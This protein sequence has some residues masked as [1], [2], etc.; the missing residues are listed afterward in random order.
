MQIFAYW[1]VPPFRTTTLD[2]EANESIDTIKKMLHD[3]FESK[4]G[5]QVAPGHL[6]LFL[7]GW[8]MEDERTLLDYGIKENWT[9]GVLVV[10]KMHVQLLSGK[11]F[12]VNHL[13]NDTIEE[14]KQNIYDDENILP[15]QQHLIFAGE[16]LDNSRT[17][18]GY[19]IPNEST[20][21]LIVSANVQLYSKS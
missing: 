19:N 18:C 13:S 8:E 7:C 4:E 21:T 2:L 20:V 15:E 12:T 16:E 11:T 10:H 14:V 17:V 3:I 9:I 1:Y 5:I 6:K